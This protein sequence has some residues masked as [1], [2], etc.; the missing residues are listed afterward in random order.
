MKSGEQRLRVDIVDRD[1]SKISRMLGRLVRLAGKVA[2][3]G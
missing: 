3:D 1:Q 2:E